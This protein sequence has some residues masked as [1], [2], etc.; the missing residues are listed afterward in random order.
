M[1]GRQMSAWTDLRCA[2]G[3]VLAAFHQAHE[4]AEVGVQDGG[5]AAARRT[6]PMRLSRSLDDAQGARPADVPRSLLPHRALS[7][8]GPPSL[9]RFFDGAAQIVPALPPFV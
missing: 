3:A 8:N 1:A 5:E 4:A 2:D 6:C 7:P 9:P